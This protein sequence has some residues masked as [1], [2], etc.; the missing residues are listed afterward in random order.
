MRGAVQQKGYVRGGNVAP[1]FDGLQ[2]VVAAPD[3]QRRCMKGVQ[4][5]IADRLSEHVWA[6]GPIDSAVVNLRLRHIEV[7]RQLAYLRV[8]DTVLRPAALL[9]MH[10][11]D[12]INND[13]TRDWGKGPSPGRRL[14]LPDGIVANYPAA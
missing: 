5:L 3:H 4:L 10:L 2:L 12:T 8:V 6:N 7:V 11:Q 1:V 14:N 9:G 13:K